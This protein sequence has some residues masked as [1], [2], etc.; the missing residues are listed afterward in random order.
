MQTKRLFVGIPLSSPLTKRLTREM[1]AW[2]DAPIILTRPN[3]LHVTVLFLGFVAEENLVMVTGSIARA[4]AGIS[5]FELSFRRVDFFP[6]NEHPTAVFMYGEENEMLLTLRQNLD[7]E[8][9]YLVP[10]K[11]S[12]RPHI[13]LGKIRRGRFEMLSEKPSVAK[14]VELIEPVSSIT[15]FESTSENG[16]RMYLPLEEFVFGALAV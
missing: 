14:T 12:F 9:G 4:A 13:T 7:R 8:L 3:N 2:R 11:K 10:E 15:L 6:N 16:K 5:P 1:E